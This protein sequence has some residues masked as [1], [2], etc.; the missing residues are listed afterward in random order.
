M[1]N[2]LCIL[3]TAVSMAGLAP[4]VGLYRILNELGYELLFFRVI[5][6]SLLF[7][8]TLVALL[9]QSDSRSFGTL[10][11]ILYRDGKQILRPGTCED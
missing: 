4:D 3:D 2:L 9:E 6:E 11:L 8:L 5:F 7:I 1:I 10:T